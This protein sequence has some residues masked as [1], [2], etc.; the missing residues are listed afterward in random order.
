[1]A[2]DASKIQFAPNGAIY[3]APAPDG[4]AGSTVLPEVVGDG[5][6]A[7]AGYNALGYA[8][9]GGVTITPAIETDPIPAWQSS[10]PVLY[11]PKSASFQVKTTLIETNQLTTELFFGAKWV[12]IL[13]EVSAP[14][15]T[16]RLDLS[17]NPE[18]TEISIVV[19]WEYKAIHNRCVIPRA[20]ISDRGAIQLQRTEGQ[21]YELTI[22]ALDYSGSLG[23]VMTD[24]ARNPSV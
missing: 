17:S 12:E 8:D 10:V 5:V 21:K 16:Y 23:Y 9:E 15:G 11:N 6:T 13:D 2:N 3:V 1:M 19:D 24:D 4:G 14:T 20:M 18:L 22:Q 7:P